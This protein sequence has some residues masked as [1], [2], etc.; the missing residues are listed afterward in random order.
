MNYNDFPILNN[1]EYELINQQF[2]SNLPFERKFHLLQ[3]CKE[4]NLCSSS[5]FVISSQYNQKI[6]H[7]LSATNKTLTKLFDN[8]TSLFNLNNKATTIENFSIF[9]FIKK[10]INL[11]NLFQDW[12][13]NEKKEYYIAIAQKSIKEINSCV[14]DICSALDESNL[15][16]YKHM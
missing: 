15:H 16:F 1:D 10:L 8:L 5:C 2:S 14:T 4:I 3:I 13:A 9:T 6:I 7:T 11:N 12:I